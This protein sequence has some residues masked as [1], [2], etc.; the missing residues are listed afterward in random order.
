MLLAV[1]SCIATE[2]HRPT[3]ADGSGQVIK[4]IGKIVESIGKYDI[5]VTRIRGDGSQF[6]SNT[7]TLIKVISV[8]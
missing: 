8:I 3:V 6:H 7:W 4:V 5:V 1:S 2:T